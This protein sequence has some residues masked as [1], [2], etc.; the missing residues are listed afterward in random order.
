MKILPILIIAFLLSG[1]ATAIPRIAA[2][3]DQLDTVDANVKN[4]TAHL[5]TDIL[6]ADEVVDVV[7]RIEDA[8]S[9]GGAV[10][11]KADLVF[12]AAIRSYADLADK[13]V[14]GLKSGAVK[15]WPELKALVDPVLNAGNTLIATAQSIGAIK[16]QVTA[17]LIKLR[18]VLSAAAGEF[19]VS[20]NFGGAR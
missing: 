4:V 14:D 16:S 10:P 9:K 8:A 13:A 5:L 6:R 15:T 19:L 20:R 2:L 1:C 17:W 18:D 12:D 7:S 3:P 11:A